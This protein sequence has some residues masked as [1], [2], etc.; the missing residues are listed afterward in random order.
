M[1]FRYMI[2]YELWF[3]TSI[4][5]HLCS[6]SVGF[7]SDFN[8]LSHDLRTVQWM[9][10]SWYFT[11]KYTFQIYIYIS[12]HLEWCDITFQIYIRNRVGCF[13]FALFLFCIFWIYTLLIDDLPCVIFFF[14]V[15]K[16]LP[17]LIIPRIHTLLL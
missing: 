8:C 10:C 5:L 14:R 17:V 11:K 3:F 15:S 1:H 2:N 9:L 12:I 7:V 13:G 6:S 4:V 16:R